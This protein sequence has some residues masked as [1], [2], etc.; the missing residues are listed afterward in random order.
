M[1]AGCSKNEKNRFEFEIAGKKIVL[2]LMKIQDTI[3]DIQAEVCNRNGTTT[4][5]VWRLDY[6]VYRFDCADIN[7]DG[8]PEIAVGVV[9]ST[10]FDSDVHK[11][12]FLFKL[13]DT[14]YVRP[15]WLGSKVSLPLVDFK[16][17]D[18]G[19]EQRIRTIEQEDENSFVIAEYEC[20]TFGV[21]WLAY[22]KRGLGLEEAVA[23]LRTE[24]LLPET[25]TNY[26]LKITN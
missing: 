3:F 7:G 10:R 1:C 18:N 16:L 15:L 24:K 23:Q 25:I 13:F 26:E 2:S 12:L 6:P 21:G 9:K 17:I 4:Q 5:S 22:L 8:I 19:K 20:K 14:C 11:R